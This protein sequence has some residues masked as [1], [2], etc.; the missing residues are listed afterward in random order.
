MKVFNTMTRKKEEFRAVNGGNVNIY[1]C[2]PTVYDLF[3]I[4]NART[5][6]FF[7]VVRRYI[8]YLGYSVKFVQNFTDI[9]DKII[10]K[11]NQR[12]M[13]V[14]EISD[15]Y[16]N[17]YYKD[18]DKLNIKRATLNPRATENIDEMID[19]IRKLLDKGVAY[20]IKGNVYFSVSRFDRYGS[21]FGQDIGT[22]KAGLRVELNDEK[23][24]QLDFVLWKRA[25]DGE[26]SYESPWGLG[27]PGWH[28]ECCSMINKY[29]GGNTI[30]IHGGGIDLVFP[31]HENEIA[32][33]ESLKDRSLANYWMHCAF[34]NI[35][36]KKMSKSLNN[37]LTVRDLLNK[38]SGNS[39][40]FCML[41]S[42]YRSQLNFSEEQIIWAEKS[43]DR[44]FKCYNSILDDEICTKI[45]GCEK[46]TSKMN[47]FKGKFIDKMNDD[48]NTSDAISVMF[49]LVKYVN[50]YRNDLGV[51]QL[52]NCKDIMDVFFEILGICVNNDICL[53]LEKVLSKETREIIL[54]RYE[55][56]KNKQFKFADSIRET[57]LCDGIILEDIVNGVRVIDSG[58]G[59]LIETILY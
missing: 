17:D 6:I 9:D 11:S 36:K 58:T 16:I 22:L 46:H 5:F 32:Q 19:L 3:H 37:F 40:R 7:D 13:S 14:H 42:H 29:F 21:L 57:L 28:T 25:K 56:K 8:E 53:N 1:V 54:K 10:H 27:R 47:Y 41:S 49:E 34:L 33:V 26:P 48:F 31:H 15:Q 52:N 38:Y 35:D 50:F 4:G 24:D 44:V 55:F 51:C 45:D 39:I 12:N 2:G 20:E 30:D 23:K 18:A 43:L 59:S